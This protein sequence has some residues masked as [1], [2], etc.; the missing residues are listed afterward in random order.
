MA[1][2]FRSTCKPFFG[3]KPL[4]QA[5]DDALSLATIVFGKNMAR[6]HCCFLNVI[7]PDSPLRYDSAVMEALCYSAQSGQATLVTSWMMLG[8]TAPTTIA[9]ASAQGF[10]EVLFGLA[11]VQLIN[12][13]APVMAGLVAVPFSMRTMRPDCG[14]PST[15]LMSMVAGHLC[16]RL[17][18]PFRCD[19]GFTS[20]K[21]VDAQAG[22]ESS[23]SLQIALNSGADFVCHAA[24]WLDNGLLVSAEK[25]RLDHD[26]LRQM[27]HWRAI[28][29]RPDDRSESLANRPLAAKIETALSDFV[30]NRSEELIAKEH[31]RH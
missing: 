25:L 7:N 19:G 20:A 15:W 30:R 11:T 23:Q 10:A 22:A 17:G 2:L 6:K 24:G 9:G 18:V 4:V 29:G 5:F 8:M 12:P 16:R 1:T 26:G 3:P 28:G 21:C 27:I 13:G 14:S 31:E